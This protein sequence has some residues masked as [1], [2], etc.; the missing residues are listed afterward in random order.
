MPTD[1]P[2][3]QPSYAE[4]I[5]PAVIIAICSIPVVLQ[6]LIVGQP[7]NTEPEA[8]KPKQKKPLEI[9]RRP[10][11]HEFL[12]LELVGIE[13]WN[14][15][16]IASIRLTNTSRSETV[17]LEEAY[18]PWGRNQN[19]LSFYDAPGCEGFTEPNSYLV[20][21]IP[22][23]SAEP[24]RV[25]VLQAGESIENKLDVTKRLTQKAKDLLHFGGESQV[26]RSIVLACSVMER[27]PQLWSDSFG[28]RYDVDGHYVGFVP[29]DW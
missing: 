22:Y 27:G 1:E 5:L 28:F 20:G 15:D 16:V 7:V 8:S 12:K 4:W 9:A 25:V 29:D 10:V 17:I 11:P 26:C 21:F 19:L 6:I 13:I 23:G 3:E 14:Q 2:G 18:L 24:E